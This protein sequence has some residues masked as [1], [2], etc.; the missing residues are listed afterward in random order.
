MNHADY[1]RKFIAN[2]LRTHGL[3]AGKQKKSAHKPRVCERF[4]KNSYLPKLARLTARILSQA[5]SSRHRIIIHPEGKNFK[6]TN[7]IALSHCQ[8][9]FHF[10]IASIDPQINAQF[11]SQSLP[12]GQI[13]QYD[14]P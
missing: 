8:Y 13:Y 7:E 10:L 3:V 9:R 1:T 12:G 11:L 2:L 14:I 5:L 6:S 4:I